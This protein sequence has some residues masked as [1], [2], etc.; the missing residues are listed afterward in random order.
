MVV[1]FYQSA[2]VKDLTQSGDYSE[3]MERF[4]SPDQTSIL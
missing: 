1:F 2:F 4:G 3:V